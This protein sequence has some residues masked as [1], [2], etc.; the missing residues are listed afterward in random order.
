MISEEKGKEI[1]ILAKTYYKHTQSSYYWN[2]KIPMKINRVLFL[3]FIFILSSLLLYISLVETSIFCSDNLDIPYLP[4]IYYRFLGFSCVCMF[5]LLLF[6]SLIPIFYK[7]KINDDNFPFYLILE[8][9][10]RLEAYPHSESIVD[11][12]SSKKLFIK[13]T[14]NSMLF[15]KF[16]LE[17]NTRIMENLDILNL[18]SYLQKNY[19]WLKIENSIIE[20]LTEIVNTKDKV[21]V[22]MQTNT[23]IDVVEKI[24]FLL[25]LFEY[26]NL[27]KMKIQKLE[28]DSDVST[29][30]REILETLVDSVEKLKPVNSSNSLIMIKGKGFIDTLKNSLSSDSI[31][32]KLFFTWLKFFIPFSILSG[33]VWLIISDFKGIYSIIA[34]TF[35]VSLAFLSYELAWKKKKEK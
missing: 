9:Y 12:N 4:I 32:Q 15:K 21:I 6:K 29:Y 19:S 14:E 27:K 7:K 23:E 3:M 25:L 33:I 34:S 31:L 28:D 24:L 26:S 2:F 30:S 11:L 18:T 20:F 35:L 17:N 16:N 8:A 22:R 13:Y 10:E 1:H 5:I